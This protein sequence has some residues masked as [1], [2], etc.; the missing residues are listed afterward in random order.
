MIPF[1]EKVT[2]FIKMFFQTTVDSS[3]YDFLF[4]DFSLFD[5]KLK[6]L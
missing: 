5:K 4:K 3:V 1:W 6:T 2:D